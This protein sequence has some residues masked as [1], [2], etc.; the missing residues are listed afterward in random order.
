MNLG[1]LVA[2]IAGAAGSGLTS[3]NGQMSL[4]RVPIHFT[5]VT[6]SAT[7]DGSE[8]RWNYD[9]PYIPSGGFIA[10]DTFTFIAPDPIPSIL[11]D[12]SITRIRFNDLTTENYLVVDPAGTA[13]RR[14]AYRDGRLYTMR[15][16]D[17]TRVILV[18]PPIGDVQGIA[19]SATSGLSGGQGFGTPDLAMDL[20]R[21]TARQF[22]RNHSGIS[23]QRRRRRVAVDND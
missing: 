3:S 22:R 4:A 16:W 11:T 6:L 18:E 14:S 1:N 7:A 20:T 10:G 13:V 19:T 12:T 2:H 15:I 21:I 17:A 8:Y 9:V 5:D 23:S